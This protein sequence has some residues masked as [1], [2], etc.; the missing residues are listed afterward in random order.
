MA[1]CNYTL[2]YIYE[3]FAEE[4]CDERV[5]NNED[6]EEFTLAT[7]LMCQNKS[8]GHYN[9]AFESFNMVDHLMGKYLSRCGELR[10]F[11]VN[12]DDSDEDRIEEND[13][14]KKIVFKL[15]S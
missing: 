15:E 9:D 6:Y 1:L 7:D 12:P 3:K 2:G 11:V 5:R 4:L 10:N 14:L 13:E 8:I